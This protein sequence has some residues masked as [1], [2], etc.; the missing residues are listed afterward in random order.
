LGSGY[1]E[2]DQKLPSHDITNNDGDY[3]REDDA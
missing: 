3:E 2:K 1:L